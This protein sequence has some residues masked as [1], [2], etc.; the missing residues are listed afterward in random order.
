LYSVQV[1]QLHQL[2]NN[3]HT[4]QKGPHFSVIQWI[5]RSV[6]SQAVFHNIIMAQNKAAL[7]YY[8]G[9]TIFSRPFI[10]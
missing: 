6:N 8:F 7:T 5:S 4:M 3:F 2:F 9:V 1:H 10:P